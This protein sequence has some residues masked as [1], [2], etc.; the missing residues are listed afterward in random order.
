MD[1]TG[2]SGVVSACSLCAARGI[3]VSANK[4]GLATQNGE[5][6]RFSWT[7]GLEL[8]QNMI[9]SLMGVTVGTPSFALE[10]LQ[11]SFLSSLLGR[12]IGPQGVDLNK[13]LEN[14]KCCRSLGLF[15]CSVPVDTAMAC[16]PLWGQGGVQEKL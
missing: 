9:I 3:S 6:M 10:L 12:K 15:S 7:E 1:H 2:S 14:K 16:D 11:N 13:T 8:T 5:A 4:D